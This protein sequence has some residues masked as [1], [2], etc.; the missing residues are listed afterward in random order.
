MGISSGG[1]FLIRYSAM[2]SIAQCP[3]VTRRSQRHRVPYGL[4]EVSNLPQRYWQAE[5]PALP[6]AVNRRGLTAA[7]YAADCSELAARLLEAG[8]LG[9]TRGSPVRA[10]LAIAHF[11]PLTRRSRRHQVPYGLRIACDLPV[12]CVRS[13]SPKAS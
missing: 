10:M 1:Y 13:R 12:R 4:R 9:R 7:S 5:T 6:H 11:P 8:G 2:L 3:L